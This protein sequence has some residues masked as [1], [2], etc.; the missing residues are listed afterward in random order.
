MSFHRLFGVACALGLS[1]LGLSVTAQP[2]AA[3][4]AAKESK[5]ESLPPRSFQR[6]GTSKFRHGARVVSLAYSPDGRYL[7]AGGADA[8]RLWDVQ[9]GLEVERKLKEPWVQ[10]VS[11]TPQGHVVATAGMF[12]TIRLVEIADGKEIHKFEGNKAG[13][14]ALGISKDL[15]VIAS[16]SMDGTL[17]IW[18]YQ[19]KNKMHEL[20]AHA[21]EITALAFHPTSETDLVATASNDRT[22]QLRKISTGELVHKLDAD[23]AP[24]AL[25]F[26]PDGKLFSAGDDNHIRV[27]DSATGKL[28]DT[29]KGHAGTVVSLLWHEGSKSLVSGSLDQTIRVWDL[30]TK[31]ARVIQRSPGD[32][33]VLALSPDGKQLASAGVNQTI[34]LF[35][36]ASGKETIPASGPKA[37]LLGLASSID[38]KRLA[39]ASSNGMLQ[40]WNAET[41]ELTRE[42]D[43]HHRGEAAV[44]FAPDQ[45]HLASA[46]DTVRIW[47]LDMGQEKMQLPVKAGDFAFSVAFQP[48]GKL[49]AVGYRSGLVEIW[50]WA[51]KQVV[52]KFNYPGPVHALAFAVDGSKLVVGGASKI[53]VWD[54]AANQEIKRFDTKDGPLASRP[55]VASLAFSP[56]GLTV[57]AGCYDG[58]VRVYDLQAGKEVFACE[59]HQSV[60]YGVAFSTDGRTL[61]SGSFDKTVCLWEAFSGQR[62]VEFK[63]H[64]GPVVGVAFSS[65]NRSVFSASGDTTI[66]AWDVTGHRKDGK[67]A[68]PALQGGDLDRMWQAFAAE[69]PVKAHASV[70]LAVAA[71]KESAPALRD[72]LYYVDPVKIDN[73]FRDLDSGN[74]RLRDNAMKQL[75]NY[76]RWMEGRYEAALKD[77]PSIEYRRRIE[78]LMQKLKNSTAP[79]LAQER[80]RTRRVM[81]VL[82]QIA[83]PVA[84]DTLQKLANGAP[85]PALQAEARAS[86]QRLANRA[87]S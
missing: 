72:M 26:A 32:N 74:F 7:V 17:F 36:F 53:I 21:D 48:A 30:G 40:L 73:L 42:W 38:G 75:T 41:S 23:C 81:L 3:D 68:P 24:Q 49:L 86:L 14:K 35:D 65:D 44:A 76:A 13:I 28:L 54:V 50:D 69:D 59:G 8:L 45:K 25:V 31:Q 62:I 55:S 64:A 84:L 20:K 56:L 51:Q 29:L 46:S 82:E 1:L 34:R 57:A 4:A 22:V 15:Q 43:G 79:T 2:Q 67:I 71:S 58:V 52:Q 61:L 33:D 6:L 78:Q 60:P 80:L 66:L 85:E 63:G 9:T 27:W 39:S 70:W 16:G 37:G 10:A 77:P 83:D 87:K 19:G 5:I 47:D 11:F 18:S 12:K